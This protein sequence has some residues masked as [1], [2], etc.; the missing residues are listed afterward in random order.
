MRIND[1]D[2]CNHCDNFEHECCGDD[3]CGEWCN[4]DNEEVKEKFY[5]FDEVIK[6]CKCFKK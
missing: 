4:C 3:A 1:G 6:D 5:D 2:I